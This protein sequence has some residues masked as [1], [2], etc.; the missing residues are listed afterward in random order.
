MKKYDVG[1]FGWWY[2]MNYGANLTYFSLNRTVKQ[3]GYSV[4]MV[5]KGFDPK[6]LP[7]TTAIRFAKKYYDIGPAFSKQE[8]YKHNDYYSTFLLGSD[9]LWSPRQEKITGE[10]FFLSFATSGKG[11]VA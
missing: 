7:D 3:L 11:K 10:D 5:W 8:M 9:Q 4:A 2:N 6:D 1:I